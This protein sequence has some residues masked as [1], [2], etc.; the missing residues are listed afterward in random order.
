MPVVHF[1]RTQ[2]HGR[3]HDKTVYPLP[4]N[5]FKT[6]ILF[7]DTYSP[8]RSLYKYVPLE[9]LL[10]L[11]RTSNIPAGF[12]SSMSVST[13]CPNTLYTD[14]ITR[15]ACGNSICIVVLGLNGLGKFCSNINSFGTPS[16]EATEVNVLN[17][18]SAKNPLSMMVLAPCS[19]PTNL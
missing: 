18:V 3:T 2:Y 16:C 8:A 13:S 4:W 19:V 14:R 12:S 17:S 5:H 9:R 11:N 1:Q 10:A 6:N 7:V 15:E